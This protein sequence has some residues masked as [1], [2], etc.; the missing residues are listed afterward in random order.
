MVERVG[1]VG[2]AGAIGRSV[3]QALVARGRS[4][5]VIGRSAPALEASFGRTRGA[6]RATWNPEDPS[7][8]RQPC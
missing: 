2:A 6:E 1:L 7:S 3:S 8:V 4:F 5:R